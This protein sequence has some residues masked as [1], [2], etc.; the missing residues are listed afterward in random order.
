VGRKMQNLHPNVKSYLLF[1]SKPESVR[2][3]FSLATPVTE[4]VAAEEQRKRCLPPLS[5]GE[6]PGRLRVT[7]H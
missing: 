6:P 4:A 1:A 7:W 2:D 5:R 3:L